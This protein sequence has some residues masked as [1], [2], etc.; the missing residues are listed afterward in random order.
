METKK[1]ERSNST[2]FLPTAQEDELS[3][4]T[5]KQTFYAYTVHG[6]Q[7]VN[8]MVAFGLL[9]VALVVRCFMLSNPPEIV[10]D[11][12]HFGGFASRYIK[13]EF[14][15]DVHPPL[16][17][18][19]VAFSGVFVG[20]NGSFSF[21]EIG[22]DYTEHHVPYVAMR[23]LPAIMGALLAPIAY[24]TMRNFG[25]SSPSA[26]LTAL[27]VT[28]ENALACQSRLILLDSYLIF[29]TGLTALMCLG[30]TA[31][32]KWVGLFT[33][34]LI[35][36]ATIQQLWTVI[37]DS[38]IPL[39]T[40]YR[41]FYARVISLIIVPILVYMFFFQVH[42][43]L[44][45]NTG[46]GNSFM[47]PDFQSTL[48]GSTVTK[49]SFKDIAYGSK[50]VIRHEDSK[51]GYLHSHAAAYPGGSKQQQITCY[52]HRDANSYFLVEYP[53]KYEN[54]TSVRQPFEGF[55]KIK[56]HDRIRLRHIE[57]Q[58]NL[59][60]H[61]VRP[62]FNDDKDVN[63][64]SCYGSSEVIGDAN[65][66]WEII[67]D[68]NGEEIEAMNTKIK[69]RHVNTGC[70]LSSRTKK[71]PEWGFGQQE[72]TCS[73]KTIHD[74]TIWRIEYSEHPEQPEGSQKTRYKPPSFLRNFIE[75]HKAMWNS[76]KGLTSSHPYESRPLDWPFLHRGISFW[77]AKPDEYGIY[78]IGN[79]ISWWTGTVSVM[80]YGLYEV[81]KVLL[82]KRQNM[83]Q[84]SS[85][86]KDMMSGLWFFAVGW[87]I[88]LFPFVLMKRQLFLHHYLPSL[89]FSLLALGAFFDIATFKLKRGQWAV[90]A[91]VLL[92]VVRTYIQFAPLTYGYKQ[93]HAACNKL[94][95]RSK[96]DFWCGSE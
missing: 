76:N 68:D 49:E 85:Y 91:V 40:F 81:I 96:W 20:Y 8:M 57:T 60:S 86:F 37:T 21:K 79:P 82:E 47:G 52:P 66:T 24:A 22:M 4:F 73:S 38:S 12:V 19:L 11:E 55:K 27:V 87:F 74:L 32:V 72:V 62:V 23:M 14:F 44:L 35:G 41:H 50:I 30:L 70:F 2:S 59:H 78:L 67:T 1:K 28:F 95:W 53:V 33:I 61:N 90:A 56:N 77:R 84:T 15:F 63:E 88:H 58:R 43:A 69:L 26:I 10:F 25:Y 9:L 3:P 7:Q 54:N 51:G 34:T 16:G 71:L 80:L 94:K 6:P 64:V 42:F 83:I 89:Y 29:F 93:T 48:V 5:E 31:S 18:L 45:T 39:K 92:I 17:K 46:P 36:I 65:D 75:L 13:G